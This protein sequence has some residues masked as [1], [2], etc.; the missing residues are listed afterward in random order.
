[1][2]KEAPPAFNEE[3]ARRFY[4]WLDHHHDEY[5][6][7]RIARAQRSFIYKFK[8]VQNHSFLRGSGSP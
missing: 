8:Y 7:I 4:R 5:T 1:M 3:D 6:E 2:R